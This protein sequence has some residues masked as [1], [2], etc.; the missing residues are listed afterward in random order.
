MV[1]EVP[2]LA[3]KVE[4]FSNTKLVRKMLIYLPK[5]FSIK[6]TFVKEAKDLKSLAIDDVETSPFFKR[7]RVFEGGPRSSVEPPSPRAHAPPSDPPYST[8]GILKSFIFR[9]ESKGYRQGYLGGECVG[10]DP[11]VDHGMIRSLKSRH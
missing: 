10:V 11:C 4:E 1:E 7:G 5:R 3:C 8:V 6:V 9:R 2:T